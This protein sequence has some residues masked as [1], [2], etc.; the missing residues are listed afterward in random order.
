M[1]YILYQNRIIKDQ[2]LH[3][4]MNDRGYMFGDGIYEVV[5]VYNKVPFAMQAHLD[6]LQQSANKLDIVIPYDEDT[7][8]QLIE[9]LI[10]K[11]RIDNGMIYFQLTRGIEP[12]NHLY[13]RDLEAILSGFAKP[14]EVNV[15]LQTSGIDLWMT[16]DI[17]WLRCDIKTI[18]LLGNVLAKREAA[19]NNCYE[20]AQHREG[21]VT[22]GS[23][24]NLFMVKDDRLYTH[25]ATNL[26]LN[27]ITRQLVIEIAKQM[28]LPI[29][30]EPFMLEQLK[31]ADE[32]FITGTTV[33]ITP[34]SS[35]Q[36]DLVTTYS[37]GEWTKKLQNQ[38][39]KL[40]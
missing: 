18:N 11:N 16:K 20:A 32:V 24:T 19:D 1:E 17:R 2:Q 40:K 4:D 9:D 12:R 38:F 5:R 29:R 10:V 31:E 15:E 37:V 22:E 27:G 39:T 30:E 36:G 14:L 3:I 13:S 35:I 33:E 28:N 21:T 23:S 25:P 34:V 7:I 6:R 26:I 8:I